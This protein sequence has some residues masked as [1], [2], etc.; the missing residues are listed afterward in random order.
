MNANME[1]DG[2]R[3]IVA[4]HSE[5]TATRMIKSRPVRR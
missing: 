4:V 5:G 3:A 1:A 2:K